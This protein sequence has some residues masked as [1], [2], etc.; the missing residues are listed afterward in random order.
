MKQIKQ[1]IVVVEYEEDGIE[2]DIRSN[3][4]DSQSWLQ[5]RKCYNKEARHQ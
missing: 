2:T 1:V 3:T 5:S 4:Q